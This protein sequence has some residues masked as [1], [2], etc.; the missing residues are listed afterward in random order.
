MIPGLVRAVVETEKLRRKYEKVELS[1]EWQR[2]NLSLLRRNLRRLQ[3]QDLIKL[4]N[5]KEIELTNKGK[6]SFIQ[7]ITQLKSEKIKEWQGTWYLVIY[8]ISNLK[9]TKQRQFRRV[10]QQMHFLQLQRSVYLTPLPC[11][12]QIKF[13][14]YQFDLNNEVMVI[15]ASKLENDHEYRKY[16][17]ITV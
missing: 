14:R 6:I 7:Q 8:D 15:E 16:F 9:H 11:F 13:L 10:L 2:F 3:K 4:T 17:G 5:H 12:E 1:R